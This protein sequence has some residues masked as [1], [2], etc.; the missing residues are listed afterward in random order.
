M[1]S[2]WHSSQRTGRGQGVKGAGPIPSAAL[3]L[4]QS[5]NAAKAKHREAVLQAENL[6]RQN[7]YDNRAYDMSLSA[8]RG[9]RRL[10]SGV[11]GKPSRSVRGP[12]RPTEPA[13][14]PQQDWLSDL[15]S[16]HNIS[17]G[18]LD[19]GARDYWSNE[20]K[21]KG[22]DAVSRSIIGTS[23]AQGTYGGRKKP[24]RI[25]TG[26]KPKRR[27]GTFLGRPIGPWLGGHGHTKNRTVSNRRRGG[28]GHWGLAA[29]GALAGQILARKSGPK[30]RRQRKGLSKNQ[31][32]NLI[33]G[34]P[35][36]F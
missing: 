30:T 15:Y 26:S 11:I 22:R 33:A 5:Q 13:M 36:F 34:T 3:A 20:A 8:M 24:Q 32:G 23:K 28:A 17:G 14:G 9:P 27:G 16:S 7:A 18:K 4:M 19:Q 1:K 6:E 12:Q 35:R 29:G 10:P 31:V 2:G 21:T 25:S